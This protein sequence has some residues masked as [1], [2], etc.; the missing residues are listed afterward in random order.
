M[1]SYCL[2]CMLHTSQL[3]QTALITLF[4]VINVQIIKLPIMH[5]FCF[6]CYFPC[7]KTQHSHHTYQPFTLL[8]G[9]KECI[10]IYLGKQCCF[11]LQCKIEENPTT[12]IH[13]CRRNDDHSVECLTYS[14]NGVHHYSQATYL[15]N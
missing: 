11:N 2:P 12:C 1:H 13:G 8:K 3:I 15:V 5:L 6:S 7:L 9:K 14:A 4:Y 10:S